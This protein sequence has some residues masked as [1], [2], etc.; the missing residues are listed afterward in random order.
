VAARH[1]LYLTNANLVSLVVRGGR[2]VERKVF[3][4]SAAGIAE[5][6]A[7]EPA[8]RRLPT[9]LITDLAEEEFRLDTIPHVGGRD[10][11]AILARKLSQLFRN[12]AYR[13][14]IAQG[15]EPEGRRDDRVVYTAITNEEILRPWVGVLERL[16][17]PVDGIH[18]AAV[19]S[20]RLLGEL[21]LVFPH[22]LLVTFTPGGAVRQAYFRDKEIKFSRL[23]PLEVEEGDSLGGF[24]AGETA[25]TW[26]YLDSQRYFA[27]TDRLEVCVLVHAR[28]RI[29]IEPVLRDYDQ[30]RYRLIDIEQ[31]AAKVGMK[32]P[33]TSSSA[34]E[35]LAHLFLRRG[36][37]N[38]FASPELRRFGALRHARIGINAAAV[39]ILAAGLGYGGWN[40]SLALQNREKELR[41][42]QQLQAVNREH[43]E[44]LRAMPA[45]GVAGQ[46]MRDSVAFYSG[47]LRDYPTVASFLIPISTVL[48]H[49]PMV[50]LTQIEWQA[51]DDDK[52]TPLLRATSPRSAPPLKSVSKGR[53]PS[54]DKGARGAEPAQGPFGSGRHAVAVLE[55]IVTIEGLGFRD[56]LAQVEKLVAE[57]GKLDGYRASILDSPLETTPAMAIQGKFGE[58]APGT[59]EARFS[60]RV[61]RTTGARN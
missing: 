8:H 34:E 27:P 38:H 15:R 11:E 18:S 7:Y 26:Q 39:V 46:T 54:D 33:P 24:L 50:R 31:A 35:I 44:V 2:V 52:V 28:D 3:A 20:G 22:A 41:T 9:N 56:A 61:A 55:G 17:V 25:R 40:L 43:D 10:R 23:T 45:Q 30:I 49:Y 19:L 58:R 53:G 37:V 51:A 5:F 13:H 42:V 6:E 47:W 1:I 4:A 59:S 16:S 36:E 57:I 48:D 29:A 14:A 60:L 21:G 32:P 12:T